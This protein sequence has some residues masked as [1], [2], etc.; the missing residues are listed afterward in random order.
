MAIGRL[1]TRYIG[2]SLVFLMIVA[3]IA[4]ASLL[5]ARIAAN[6]AS[7]IGSLRT[8]NTA[9]VTYPKRVPR[10]RLPGILAESWA[11]HQGLHPPGR[12]QRAT[13]C[14]VSRERRLSLRLHAAARRQ[15]D[16]YGLSAIGCSR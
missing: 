9:M 12:C 7:A 14:A 16:C 15:S 3:A 5:R 2:A 10:Y 8:Y 6:D 13:C 1:V 4:I 11:G